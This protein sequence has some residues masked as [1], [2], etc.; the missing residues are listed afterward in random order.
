MAGGA[1]PLMLLLATDSKASGA[2]AP[3]LQV[4]ESGQRAHRL[5]MR[6]AKAALG[7]MQVG[8]GP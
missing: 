5:C 8:E 7:C 1:S 6:T 4:R 2:C 3:N